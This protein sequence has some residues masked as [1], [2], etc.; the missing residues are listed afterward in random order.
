[1]SLL[2]LEDIGIHFALTLAEWRSWFHA[3]ADEVRELG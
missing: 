2:H 1:L 3:S